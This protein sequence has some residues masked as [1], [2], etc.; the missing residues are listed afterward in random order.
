MNRWKTGVVIASGVAVAF[1][2]GFGWQYA[3]AEAIEDQADRLRRELAFQTLGAE[4]GAAAFDACRGSYEPAR[5][6]ASDFFTGLQANIGRA[7]ESVAPDF[8]AILAERD[9]V[10]TMLSRA[11]PNSADTLAVLFARYRDA[12]AK[13]AGP[14]APAAEPGM[15]PPGAPGR[16]RPAGPDTAAPAGPVGL[17]PVTPHGAAPAGARIAAAAA[18]HEYPTGDG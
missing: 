4:L 5:R 12:A 18:S 11:E 9:D 8:S 6:A 10:I 3:R 17:A 16:G 14:Q 13:T 2:A 15:T 1:L 7:P